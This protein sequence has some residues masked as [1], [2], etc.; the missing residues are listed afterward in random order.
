MSH[1]KSSYPG[2]DSVHKHPPVR[3]NQKPCPYCTFNNLDAHGHRHGILYREIPGL[4]IVLESN[5]R[6]SIHR[7]DL[8]TRSSKFLVYSPMLDVCPFCNRKL[9]PEV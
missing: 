2:M 1:T 4:I 7:Y 3:R 8:I 6:L 9:P 5:H